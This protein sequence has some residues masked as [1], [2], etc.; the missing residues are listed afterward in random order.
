MG[1]TLITYLCQWL[2]H[3]KSTSDATSTGG[4][5][6]LNEVDKNVPL[7]K[8]DCEANYSKNFQ[9]Y[10]LHINDEFCHVILVH[11]IVTTNYSWLD[12]VPCCLWQHWH[13]KRAHV[14]YMWPQQHNLVH[15]PHVFIYVLLGKER[16]IFYHLVHVTSW[17]YK[18]EVDKKCRVNI[19]IIPAICVAEMCKH[20]LKLVQWRA[21]IYSESDGYMTDRELDI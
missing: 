21:A 1:T 11:H 9:G 19:K 16:P 15:C 13:Q 2:K 14:Q 18:P 20:L 6:A 17:S 10:M 4:N 5:Q 12:H 3:P 8:W 7:H